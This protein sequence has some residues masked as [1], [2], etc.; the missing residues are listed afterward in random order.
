METLCNE[1][2]NK[3]EV[4]DKLIKNDTKA[5]LEIENMKDIIFNGNVLK[6]EKNNEK[7]N[8][9]IS[10]VSTIII[11]KMSSTI[12]SEKYQT[13]Q[14]MSLCEFPVDQKF[15]LIYKATKDGFEASSFHS[16]CN[17]KP[18]TLIIIKSKN[19]NVFC[20]YTEQTW[21][22][23]YGCYKA[24]PNSFIFSLINEF[25]KPIKIKCSQSNSI[26]CSS[27]YGPSFGM[28]DLHIADKSN[29][30]INTK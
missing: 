20:G 19:D 3:N 9:S 8:K 15:N 14:P 4:D 16:K 21:N 10:G 28:N 1:Y 6:F 18:N 27:D 23:A 13:E 17:D 25:N 22:H 7:I 12:L 2:L 11:N 26:Y 29:I 30:N 5:K 24:D